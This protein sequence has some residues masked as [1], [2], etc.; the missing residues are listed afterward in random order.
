MTGSVS[1][2]RQSARYWIRFSCYLSTIDPIMASRQERQ[3]VRWLLPR[4]VA[5]AN[6]ASTKPAECVVRQPPSPHLHLIHPEPEPPQTGPSAAN[7]GPA[8]ISGVAVANS[9]SRISIWV[10]SSGAMNVTTVGGPT[11]GTLLI[12]ITEYSRASSRVRERTT[13]RPEKTTGCMGCSPG[14]DP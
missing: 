11:G 13:S 3:I 9:S 14:P 4:L 6:Y 5:F 1:G 7:T 8:L 10:R 2:S 12:S